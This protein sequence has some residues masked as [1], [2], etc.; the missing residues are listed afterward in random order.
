[1]YRLVVVEGGAGAA[2][3]VREPERSGQN[4]TTGIVSMRTR[5]NRNPRDILGVSANVWSLLGK[6]TPSTESLSGPWN[7]R[8]R[9]QF[10]IVA[11]LIVR[12]RAV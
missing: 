11:V 3:A 1:M 10:F 8:E 2:P 7:T 4:A 9:R 6:T 5:V 12:T